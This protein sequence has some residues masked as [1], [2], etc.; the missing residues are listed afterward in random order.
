[1]SKLVGFAV[2]VDDTLAHIERWVSVGCLIVIVTV[3]ALGVFFRYVLADP[4][5]WSNS[6]G[7]VAL[8]WLTFIGGSLLFKTDDHINITAIPSLLSERAWTI[9][10]TVFFAII[11]ITV[12]TVAW[13]MLTL[14][15]LQ[16]KKQIEALS[17]PR[18]VYGIPLMWAMLSIG[19]SAAARILSA[20]VGKGAQRHVSQEI[21]L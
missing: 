11:C 5:I 6:A 16:A 7:I 12:L 10:S 2:G 18:S 3:T 8:M 17:L 1:M 4:L 14:I 13:Q 20:L 9:L 21:G 19:W 15:P